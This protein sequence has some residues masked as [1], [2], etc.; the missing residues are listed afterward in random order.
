MFLKSSYTTD[1]DELP[2]TWGLH[3]ELGMGFIGEEKTPVSLIS[4]LLGFLGYSFGYSLNASITN[5]YLSSKQGLSYVYC[6]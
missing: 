3:I 5:V 2:A 6:E 1:S 4:I